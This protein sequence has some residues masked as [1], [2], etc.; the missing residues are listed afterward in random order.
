MESEYWNYVCLV[1]SVL[2]DSQV[3]DSIPNSA[4]FR[5]HGL[6]ANDA[7]F[8]FPNAMSSRESLTQRRYRES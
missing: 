4:R 7:R 1:S 5:F 3:P 8:V 6:L 2:K